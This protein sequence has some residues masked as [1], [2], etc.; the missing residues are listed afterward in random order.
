MKEKDKIKKQML[1]IGV[2]LILLTV[3]L[4]GC[5]ETK[6]NPGPGETKG[7]IF[8]NEEPE[9]EKFEILPGDIEV[10]GDID[11]IKI[12]D[13]EVHTELWSSMSGWYKFADGLV[14]PSE[15][16]YNM[17]TVQ[18]WR[19][20]VVSGTAQNIAGETLPFVQISAHFYDDDGNPL[21]GAS[22]YPRDST[23][24]K[25][26]GSIFEF[27]ISIERPDPHSGKSP[28]TF[29]SIANFSISVK[30]LDN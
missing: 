8:P 18:Q 26:D 7:P 19:K 28:S 11:K 27:I 9:E 2:T 14:I 23:D 13:Y 3:G 20:Y 22:W 1:I 15:N 6:L 10:T 24:Y 29:D 12:L 16:D 21:T 25:M 5:N 30:V 17:Y 4:S